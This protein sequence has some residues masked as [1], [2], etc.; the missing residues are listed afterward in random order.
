MKSDGRHD[1]VSASGHGD[2][3]DTQDIKDRSCCLSYCLPRRC[4]IDIRLLLC[5]VQILT[6]VVW[7]AAQA[8]F[9]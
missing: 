4:N 2:C 3:S 5:S 8:A 7:L 1:M 9:Y 6:I